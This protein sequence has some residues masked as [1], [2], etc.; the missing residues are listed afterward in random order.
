MMRYCGSHYCSDGC[1]VERQWVHGIIIRLLG[2]VIVAITVI[3]ERKVLGRL[4]LR[5]RPM[6]VRWWGVLQTIVDG[7]KLL[8]KG[9]VGGKVVL[10]SRVFVAV[11][12]RL[13]LNYGVGWILVILAI[14]EYA[15]IAGVYYSYSI[16]SMLRRLRAII[17]ILAYDILL[18]MVL[19]GDV[20]L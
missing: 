14:M 12:C 2:L 11:G 18:L 10:C 3:L 4:Q 19:I 8:T 5:T 20:N 7:V 17:S 16:Y 15:F 1:R 13:N 9:V 6:V